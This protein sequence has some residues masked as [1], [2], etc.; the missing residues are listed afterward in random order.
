MADNKHALIRYNIL[1]KCLSNSFKQ[2]SFDDLLNACNLALEDIFPGSKGISIRTL[3]DDLKHMR[4]A[5]GWNAPIEVYKKNGKS[6]YRYGEKGFTIYKQPLNKNERDQLQAAIGTFSR[7]QGLPE[8]SWVSELSAKLEQT[9]EKDKPDIIGFDNNEYLRGAEYI[10][11]LF[12]FILNRQTLC[13]TYHPF[14]CPEPLQ[15]IMHPYYL[16]QYN[17]RWFLFGL[18]DDLKKITIVALDR[19]LDLTPHHVSYIENHNFDFK[20]YF[21]DIIGVSLIEG[22]TLQKI[23]L[24]FNAKAAPYVESKPLH[25]SQKIISRSQ[26]DLVISIEVIPNY[27]LESVILSYGERVSVLEPESFKKKIADRLKE[28]LKGYNSTE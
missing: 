13:I 10:G 27:E 14:N 25:G 19:I 21:D 12:H 6:F 23:M 18:N 28:A 3:R 8:F 15:Y 5:E 20:D 24:R 1:D 7:I 16:K 9:L 11:Q 2:Y 22:E 4:S 17:N 26:G